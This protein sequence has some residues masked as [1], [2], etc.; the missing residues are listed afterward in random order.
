[1]TQLEQHSRWA[2]WE[3]EVLA[4]SGD[5]GKCRAVIAQ[6]QAAI[7]DDAGEAQ[8]VRELIVRE[9]HGR[10]HTPESCCV[11]LP[12]GFLADLLTEATAKKFGRTAVTPYLKALCI[13][14]LR[15]DRKS[16]QRGW[17]WR[18]SKAKKDAKSIRLNPH[19]CN[20][21]DGL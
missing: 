21:A 16:D 12:L 5:S 6:R 19:C 13:F 1:M 10:Q 9:L 2:A 20:L 8:V 18:G 14:E 11:F 15:E 17:C 4:K 3:Q 7:D